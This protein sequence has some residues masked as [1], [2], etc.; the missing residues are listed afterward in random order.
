MKAL[1]LRGQFKDMDGN[2]ALA[3]HDPLGAASVSEGYSR[4]PV[5]SGVF[6]TSLPSAQKSWQDAY[7]QNA[8]FVWRVL[9]RLGLSSEDAEDGLHE[10]FLVAHTRRETY[11]PSRGSM[12]SW[13]F[14]IA[15]N[16]AR[17]ERRRARRAGIPTD[18]TN[19][20]PRG[21]G[22]G[23]PCSEAS[24]RAT[25]G[26]HSTEAGELKR[27]LILALGTLSPEHRIVF[28]M[29]EIE[30]VPCAAIG[31]E[32]QIPVGTVYSRLHKAREDLRRALKDHTTGKG[33]AP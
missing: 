25:D 10:V 11:D 33:R 32:L 22:V 30:G 13:L 21:S 4:G 24:E 8:A 20:R 3:G 17:S 1:P 16:I 27:A 7:E 18:T 2:L 28:E 9:R 5:T 26:A 31:E 23:G 29:F 15:S 19:E 14:G 6:E 12:R